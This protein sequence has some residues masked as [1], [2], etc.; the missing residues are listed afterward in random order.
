M[1]YSICTFC[2]GGTLLR[3]SSRRIDMPSVSALGEHILESL[4]ALLEEWFYTDGL[5]NQSS[6]FNM[7]NAGTEATLRRRGVFPDPDPGIFL[8]APP[9]EGLFIYAFTYTPTHTPNKPLVSSA[10]I[11]SIDSYSASGKVS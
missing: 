11:Y 1:L 10:N 9:D 7:F 2:I 6:M 5:F 8:R 4:P 3:P